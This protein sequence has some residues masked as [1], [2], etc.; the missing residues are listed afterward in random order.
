MALPFGYAQCQKAWDVT[1]SSPT[2]KHRSQTLPYK[3]MD[4]IKYNVRKLKDFKSSNQCKSSYNTSRVG[5]SKTHPE[6][7]ELYQKRARSRGQKVTTTGDVYTIKGTSHYIQGIH[8]DP[9]SHDHISPAIMVNSRE[10]E[11][12]PEIH[13]FQKHQWVI[14]RPHSAYFPMSNPPTTPDPVSSTEHRSRSPD[15]RTT[16]VHLFRLKKAHDLKCA[17]RANQTPI[18]DCT[19]SLKCCKIQPESRQGKG[20]FITE[21][22]VTVENPVIND[23]SPESRRRSSH[24]SNVPPSSPSVE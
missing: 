7:H 8:Y 18:S 10:E 17:I 13:G 9:K 3:S 2:S 5:S 20:F 23:E 1:P 11:F 6:L 21:G 19:S 22:V 24:H 16:L 12:L 14:A 15:R 4:L